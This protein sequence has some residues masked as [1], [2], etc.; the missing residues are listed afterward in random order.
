MIA[1]SAKVH[2]SGGLS[3]LK[4]IGPNRIVAGCLD[5][6]L[7][8][9]N[10]ERQQV[11][12][13]L[14]TS[15]KVAT[16]LDSSKE[17]TLITGH[18]D[19]TVRLWDIRSGQSEKTFKQ[20]YEGHEKWISQVKFNQSVDNLFLSGSY[21]GTV[22]LWDIRNEETALATMKHQTQTDDYKVFAVEWNG[23]SQIISGGSDSHVSIHTIGSGK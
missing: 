12:E 7:K 11:E 19:A 8:L 23:S 17:T 10:A 2:C 15:H 21:D 14:F 22:R 5:H 6:S 3:S 9:I 4:W 16:C 13:I 20:K 18:E 1:P